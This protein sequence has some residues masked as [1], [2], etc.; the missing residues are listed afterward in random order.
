MRASSVSS[1]SS[2]ASLALSSSTKISS[3]KDTRGSICNPF[4]LLP[5]ALERGVPLELVGERRLHC[6]A[7]DRQDLSNL[8]ELASSRYPEGDKPFGLPRGLL[9]DEA[10]VP[11]GLETVNFVGVLSR[12][13]DKFVGEI[14][15]PRATASRRVASSSDDESWAS[16]ESKDLHGPPIVHVDVLCPG[17]DHPRSCVKLCCQVGEIDKDIVGGCEE[18]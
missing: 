10:V 1:S 6:D 2:S 5:L 17:R 11:T 9:G 12:L 7:I 18:S 4:G 15:W 8:S 14:E 13:L 3:S 16:V